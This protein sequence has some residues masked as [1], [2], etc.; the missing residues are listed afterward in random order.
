[1]NIEVTLN[2]MHPTRFNTYVRYNNILHFL[3]IIY[4]TNLKKENHITIIIIANVQIVPH[5]GRF[6]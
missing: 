2:V 5:K 4:S 1:M 6:L 3:F